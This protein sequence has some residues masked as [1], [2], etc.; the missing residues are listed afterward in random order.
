MRDLSEYSRVLAHL[1]NLKPEDAWLEMVDVSDRVVKLYTVPAK[2]GPDDM[3]RNSILFIRDALFFWEYVLSIKR[4][5]VGS[6][7]IILKYWAVAFQ[8]AGRTNYAAE[9]LHLC[10][11]TTHVWPEDLKYE[12]SNPFLSFRLLIHFIGNLFSTTFSSTF[13]ENPMDGKNWTCYKST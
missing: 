11:S 2:A 12:P 9:L 13:Q 6:V 10:H 5:D 8:G 7:F 1:K 3:R 4:G